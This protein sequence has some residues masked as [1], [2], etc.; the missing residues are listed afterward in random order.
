MGKRALPASTPP[1]SSGDSAPRGNRA[2]RNGI[3]SLSG[4]TTPSRG[5]DSSAQ[6]RKRAQQCS[7]GGLGLPVGKAQGTSAWTGFLST[8]RLRRRSENNRCFICLDKLL[9]GHDASISHL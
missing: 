4:T 2:P 7:S 8:L 9:L 1:S 3:A 6:A 5:C